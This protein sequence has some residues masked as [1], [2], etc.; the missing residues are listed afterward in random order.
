MSSAHNTKSLQYD[1]VT[2]VQGFWHGTLVDFRY[3]LSVRYALV[4]NG[5]SYVLFTAHVSLGRVADFL[6]NVRILIHQGNRIPSLT[7]STDWTT[8]C[9]HRRANGQCGCWFFRSPPCRHWLWQIHILL[10]QRS[11]W[12]GF[13][14]FKTA[15]PFAHRQWA[16]FQE[17]SLQ[18][19]HRTY[20]LRQNIYAY[21]SPRRDALHS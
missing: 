12:W 19:H 13:N 7:K 3:I 21:G 20:G 15:I 10:V 4:G 1:P 6:Y 8:G 11:I 2:D 14:S 16:R 9:L 5:L 17:R 18:S